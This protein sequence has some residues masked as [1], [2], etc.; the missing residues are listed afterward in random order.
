MANTILLI[1]LD[2]DAMADVRWG[3]VGETRCRFAARLDLA[4]GG[5]ELAAMAQGSRVVVLVP[6]R[7]VVLR[8]TTFQGKARQATPLALAYSHETGLLTDVEQMHWAVLGKVQ[9]D[10]TIA[11]VALAQMQGWVDSLNACG[12]RVDALLPDVLALPLLNQCSALRWRGHWLL[13]T[14]GM[15]GMQLPDAW[16][17]SVPWP[18]PDWCLHSG[19]EVPVGWETARIDE[20][21]LW[22]LAEEAWNSTSTLLQ[23]RFKPGVRWP[24]RL[25][26]KTACAMLLLSGSLLVGGLHHQLKARQSESQI[27]ALTQRLLPSGE[28]APAFAERAAQ[29]WA[30]RMQDTLNAPQ[31]FRLLPYAAEAL[32]VWEPP[33]L[34]ALA[35]DAA[36]DRLV[37]TVNRNDAPLPAP[38]NDG[39]VSMT[40]SEGSAPNQAILTVRGER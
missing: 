29:T 6:A 28:T 25:P 37:V 40:F 7:H 26:D 23:G 3:R 30:R 24:R 34:Q 22:R 9:R 16:G 39:G 31:L 32:A 2:D 10:F 21:P 8:Q 17:D 18:T 15:Q 36:D 14:G 38:V 35:F 12:I 19:G 13:R 4:E 20:D 1:A 33:Q 27:T 11:G 5:S